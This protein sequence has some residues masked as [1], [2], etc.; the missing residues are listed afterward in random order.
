MKNQ[1]CST[2]LEALSALI[3]TREP[4]WT[5]FFSD[6]SRC[7]LVTFCNPFSLRQFMDNTRYHQDIKEFE[8]V[9]ADGILLSRITSWVTGITTPRLAFD[10]NSIALQVLKQ[11]TLM[12]KSIG[13]VGGMPGEVE[14]AVQKLFE[15]GIPVKFY[16]HGYFNAQER[17][18]L[19]L[20]AKSQVD[21]LAVG[22]G[23]PAQEAF[24]VDLKNLGWTGAGFTC[25][26]YISQIAARGV[27]Y[28]P[29]AI[30]KLHLRMF[31]RLFHEPR[32][33]LWRYSIGYLPFY[34]GV[35]ARFLKV[36]W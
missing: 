4:D 25:G 7:R 24:L 34:K 21:V 36:L 12:S 3:A 30:N 31:F 1:D 29:D 22:M 32:K 11:A 5:H 13:L 8:L 17:D 20:A 35:G 33:L 16:H 10:G 23:A 15:A 26:A 2:S 19:L 27:R 6:D 14:I 9:F 18:E 28:Y